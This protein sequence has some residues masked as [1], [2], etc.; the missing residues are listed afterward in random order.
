MKEKNEDNI[1]EKKKIK[2]Q[3]S[4]EKKKIKEEKKKIKQ[5]KKENKKIKKENQLVQTIKYKWLRETSFTILLVVAVISAYVAINMVTKALDIKDI[6][7][8]REKRYTLSSESKNQIDKIDKNISI[9]V[10]G[11]AEDSVE[12]DLAKQ[13]ESYGNNIHVELVSVEERPDLAE[14]YNIKNENYVFVFE[15]EGRKIITDSSKFS[16]YNYNNSN[17]YYDT[18][19]QAITN[20]ILAVSLENVPKIYF[21]TGHNEYALNNYLTK[22]N[23]QLENEANKVESL[24]LLVKNE[25]PEDCDSLVIANPLTDFT[26]YETE[27]LEKYIN[28]GGNI[29]WLSDYSNNGTLENQQKILD[30]YGVK[31]INDGIVLEQD[32]ES[33]LSGSPSMILPKISKESEITSDISD[34]GLVLLPMSGM[35][36]LKTNN[37]LEELDVIATKLL[38]TTDKA[39]FRKNFKNSN[40]YPSEDENVNEYILGALLEKTI[41]NSE[42]NVKTSK[43]IIY[44]NAILATDQMISFGNQSTACINIYKNKDLIINSIAYL[45]ERKDAITIRKAFTEVTYTPTEKQNIIVACI[46]FIFPIIIII[47]GLGVWIRR[48]FRK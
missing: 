3:K 43:L 14:Q 25:I 26:D 22:L 12:V 42:D 47:V 32:A 35:I 18:A 13:Y 36:E 7:L 38:T 9:Y 4:I 16:D 19:E 48:R 28:N 30:L 31:N 37:E 10:F 41:E 39:F 8:T 15:C 2:E 5:E 40:R 1:N 33:M 21:L 44:A 45:T 23:F 29:M 34:N 20:S 24:N 46:I 17:E 11:F 27:I 6:D